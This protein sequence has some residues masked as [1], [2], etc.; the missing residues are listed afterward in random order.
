[1]SKEMLEYAL[2]KARLNGSDQADAILAESVNLN[3][4]QRLGK[5]EKLERAEAKEL[6]LRAFVGKRQA[7]V[8]TNDLSKESLDLLAER[9]VEMAKVVPEDPFCGL[10]EASQFTN[11]LIDLDSLD[12]YEPS[13]ADLSQWASQAEDSA[14][15]IAGISNSEGAETGW[16][17]NNISLATSTGFMGETRQSR[18]GLSV[19][20]IAG[21]GTAMER[22]YDYSTSVYASDLK[23]PIAI[24]KDAATRAM[25]R[26]NPKKIKSAQMPVIFE[27]RL[28]NSLLSHFSSAIN[29]GSVARGTTFLKDKM[30][31]K[32]FADNITIM[33]DPRRKRGLRSRSFDGEGLAAYPLTLVEN[34][35]LQDWILDCRSA[36]QLGLVSNGRASRGIGSG[37]SPSSTNLYMTCGATSPETMIK[38]IK[39]GLYVT[40]LIG[41]GVNQITGDYSRGAA[42]F[43]IEGGELTSAVSEI[44]IAGN[45][46]DMFARLIPANDLKFQYG[47]D[48][49]TILIED[50]MVAGQ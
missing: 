37:I 20:V 30:G 50:M 29:G 24:G 21:S 15:G 43:L 7:I 18:F 1:M 3:L 36:R 22:D 42:G 5:K 19:S 13:E 17:R 9:V 16:S 46:L 38:S 8:S 4:S 14:L 23:S 40:E 10:P 33:D 11:D 48:S 47:T 12:S 35:V 49:P 39:Y 44:T 31:K 34:G 6:G 2:N 32:I 28:A 41:F 25:R 26:L 45:L 27:P